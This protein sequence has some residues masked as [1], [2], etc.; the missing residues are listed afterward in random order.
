MLSW[1]QSRRASLHGRARYYRR[2]AEVLGLVQQKGSGYELTDLGLRF[3]SVD[4]VQRNEL[5]AIQLAKIPAFHEILEGISNGRGKQITRERV[6]RIL[7]ETRRPDSRI[8]CTEA[9]FD[10][11]GVAPLASEH[12]GN[13]DRG[14]VGNRPSNSATA[15]LRTGRGFSSSRYSL[16]EVRTLTL[17]W[18]IGTP[19]A[20]R[21]G[22]WSGA[23][24]GEVPAA[25]RHASTCF[26]SQLSLGSE[27]KI[28]FGS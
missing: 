14:C 17:R 2:A 16:A 20:F 3:V 28:G 25:D 10:S 22:R 6:A 21:S 8:N 15:L 7:Q 23:L 9:N 1:S 18:A 11:S 5:V 27:L 4:T 12:N 13:T 19:S 24:F 26:G